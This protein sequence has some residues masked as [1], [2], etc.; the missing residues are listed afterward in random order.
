[1]SGVEESVNDGVATI[2]IGGGVDLTKPNFDPRKKSVEFVGKW[3]LDN[4]DDITREKVDGYVA[5]FNEFDI[6][7]DH[8]LNF[9]E[10]NRMLEKQGTPKTRQEVLD[11]IA[12]IDSDQDGAV[13]FLEFLNLV[14]TRKGNAGSVTLTLKGRIYQ[15]KL[16]NKAKFFETEALKQQSGGDFEKEA[17]RQKQLKQRRKREEELRLQKEEQARQ[18]A[19]ERRKNFMARNAALFGGVANEV[20]K[21]KFQLKKTPKPVEKKPVVENLTVV[22]NNG[23]ASATAKPAAGGSYSVD[24]EVQHL[25]DFIKKLGSDQGGKTVVTFGTLFQDDDVAN[26]LESLA[27]TLK[28]AKKRGL[29]SY[30]PELLLQGASDNEPITLN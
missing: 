27:G 10:V 5:L 18:E 26:T 19:A 8:V 21:P 17:L 12:E 1:M 6:D 16:A 9:Y 4:C 2:T 22:S 15:S 23:T 13:N 25:V 29:I 7:G 30:G 11:M 3:F 24:G 14:H 20:T 28:A